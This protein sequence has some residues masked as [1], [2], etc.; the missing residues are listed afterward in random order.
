MYSKTI[1]GFTLIEAMI[2]LFIIGILATIAY[3]SYVSYL[4][5]SHRSDAMATLAQ[6]QITLERCYAQNFSYNQTCSFLPT[7]PQ[8]SA[9]GY[10]NIT[11]TNLSAS[12]Y[13]LTA[14]AIG[15]QTE[16]TICALF[17]IDQANVK[18]AADSSGATQTLC[19]NPT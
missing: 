4:L 15:R 6:N 5:K 3:P 17:I 10:Y 19:W 11:L 2:V 12:T 13:T 16:D 7:F 1:R 14:T 9:K 8:T 18:T